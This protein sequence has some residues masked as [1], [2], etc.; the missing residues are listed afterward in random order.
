MATTAVARTADQLTV[1]RL[2]LAALLVVA[3]ASARLVLA[4][5]ILILCWITD[6]LDGILARRAPGM[7]RFG[8]WDPIFDGMMGLGLMAGMVLGGYV[9]A[10]WLVPSLLLG[11]LLFRVRS[12]ASGMLLQGMAY[13]WFLRTLALEDRDALS[14]VLFAIGVAAI[15]HGHRIPRV[16]IPRFFAD[17]A[18]L[19][20][21]EPPPA[22]EE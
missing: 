13:A 9:S 20:G 15:T 12:L 5:G 19:K 21:G 8:A 4:A 7:T 2:P 10:L 22:K 11:G 6:T 16:L 1:A 14:V 3:I 17:V 18:R